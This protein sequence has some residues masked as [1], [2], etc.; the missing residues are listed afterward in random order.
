MANTSQACMAMM[1]YYTCS[2]ENLQ[3]GKQHLNNFTFFC[4]TVQTFLFLYKYSGYFHVVWVERHIPSDQ[5]H[6]AACPPTRAMWNSKSEHPIGLGE[7]GGCLS[8]IQ[9]QV[10]LP[11]MHPVSLRRSLHQAICESVPWS[12]AIIHT[13]SWWIFPVSFLVC[14][15]VFQSEVQWPH[16]ALEANRSAGLKEAF[17][18]TPLVSAVVY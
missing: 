2:A 5:F 17:H 18:R 4:A 13:K 1:T 16:Q 10:S 8:K 15:F 9:P 14:V 6:P 12:F 11:L 7:K 3:W